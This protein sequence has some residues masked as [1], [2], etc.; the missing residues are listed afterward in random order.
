MKLEL[1]DRLAH[2]SQSLDVIGV[3]VH[4]TVTRFRK[5]STLHPFRTLWPSPRFR[6]PSPFDSVLDH[7]RFTTYAI[8]SPIRSH[9]CSIALPSMTEDLK[10]V[11]NEPV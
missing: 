6:S 5:R 10:I 2:F 7:L 4:K 8:Q 9:T 1:A 11:I 3:H